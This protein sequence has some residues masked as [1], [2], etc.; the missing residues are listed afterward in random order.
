MSQGQNHSGQPDR[1]IVVGLGNPGRRY[2][3]TRHNV[4]FMVVRRL[5]ERSGCG[6]PKK[7]F[8]GRLYDARFAT[9]GDRVRKAWLFEPLTYVNC[10]GDAIRTLAEF[11]RIPPGD[12]LVI[13]D[14]MALPTGR[15][16]ARAKGSAGGHNGL[17]DIL[18]AFGGQDL[19]RLRVGIGSP[20][21]QMDPR[22]YVLGKFSPEE[23]KLIDQAVEQAADAAEQWLFEGI[24]HVMNR[25][26]AREQGAGGEPGGAED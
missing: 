21:P 1:K 3:D 4:G 12:V 16:R 17:D 6:R 5:A 22:D 14:D 19:P 25:Y 7:A 24:T 13:V 23:A 11:H 8:N 9:G 18:R 10:C 2:R 15:L 20:P 26:N